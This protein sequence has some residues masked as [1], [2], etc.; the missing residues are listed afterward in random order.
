MIYK[1]EQFLLVL[2]ILFILKNMID[3]LLRLFDTEPRVIDLN[4]YE[5]ITLYASIAYIVTYIFF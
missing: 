1:I 5:K 4:K 2:S 3:F